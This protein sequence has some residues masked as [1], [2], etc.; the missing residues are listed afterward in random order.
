MTAPGTHRFHRAPTGLSPC[1][2]LAGPHN[3]HVAGAGVGRG[4]HLS[5][6]ETDAVAADIDACWPGLTGLPAAP[7]PQMLRILVERTLRKARE[8]IAA[9]AD[10]DF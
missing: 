6:A 5:D 9:R 1:P 10:K 3:A 8:T 2:P 7:T 4:L